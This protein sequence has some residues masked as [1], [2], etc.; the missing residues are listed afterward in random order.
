M[1]AV[2]PFA[3]TIT[4]IP[5]LFALSKTKGL[6]EQWGSFGAEEAGAL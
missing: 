5:S 4:C 6:I 1:L 2:A 3:A